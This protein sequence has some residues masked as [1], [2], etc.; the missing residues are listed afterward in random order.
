M[1][2]GNDY[3]D[4]LSIDFE[5]KRA[6]MCEALTAAGLKPHVPQGSY[7][8]LAD[9]SSVPGDSSKE[10]ALYILHKTGV[11]SVPG[12]AFYHDD[13]GEGLARFCFA[14]ED[15][16]LEDACKRLRKLK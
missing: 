16:I 1:K 12:N 13:G 8:V 10:K 9:I 3:Y 5:E 2:L 6:M 11:A 14:K 4:G 15:A 7:Y